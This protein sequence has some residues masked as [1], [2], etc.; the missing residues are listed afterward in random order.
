MLLGASELLCTLSGLL[1]YTMVWLV[2][3][4]GRSL[5]GTHCD[6]LY[7]HQAPVY[8][9]LCTYTCFTRLSSGMVVMVV[10][11]MAASPNAWHS[12]M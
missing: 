1:G 3:P 4:G 5:A 8:C 2:G 6:T 10:V 9:V 7:M 12:T 11:M